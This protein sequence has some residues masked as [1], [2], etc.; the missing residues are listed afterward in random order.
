[1][2]R[3]KVMGW[4]LLFASVGWI[5]TSAYAPDSATPRRQDLKDGR[6]SL[7]QRCRN[8]ILTNVQLRPIGVVGVSPVARNATA[9]LMGGSLYVAGNNVPS[10]FDAWPDFAALTIV[11]A[12]DPEQLI[13]APIGAF[14]FLSPRVVALQDGTIHLLWGEYARNSETPRPTDWLSP[15]ADEV[16]TAWR[17][18]AGLWSKPTR[19]FA[20]RTLW[21]KASAGQIARYN[22]EFALAAPH[23]PQSAGERIGLVVF[24]YRSYAW[25]VSEIATVVSPGLSA[26]A[27]DQTHT[28]VVFVAADTERKVRNAVFL[29]TK[30]RTQPEF[31]LPRPL[32]PANRNPAT[33][34][35]TSAGGDSR[36]H[37]VWHSQKGEGG[38]EISHIDFSAQNKDDVG[39]PHSAPLRGDFQYGA[40]ALDACGVFHVA[41]QN[42]EFGRPGGSLEYVV[43][44][45]AWQA[46]RSVFSDMRAMD[47][48][49]AV[50]SA[51]AVVLVVLAQPQTA[52]PRSPYSTMLAW[53]KR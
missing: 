33:F 20:G 34:V 24:E 7:L 28:V 18:S 42:Y 32:Q 22:D 49:F 21:D 38:S 48:A 30:N 41:F 44:N 50:D 1:M 52:P 51:G 23:F 11:N 13:I 39:T 9:S 4:L 5:A 3:S 10:F 35:A 43:W 27:I 8:R 53:I 19:L 31:E 2:A 15:I 6:N 46:Q 12:G 16:W 45:G 17:S 26:T 14:R 37:V 25:H 29:A 36:F 47:P 40:A